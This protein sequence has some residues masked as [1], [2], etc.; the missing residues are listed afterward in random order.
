[1]AIYALDFDGNDKL[2]VPDDSSLR[3]T[4]DEATIECW[5]KWNANPTSLG[6][7]ITKEEGNAEGLVMNVSSS[8]KLEAACRC[9]SG[10]PVLDGGTTMTA[11][12]NW[13]HLA[14]VK[15]ATQLRVFLDGVEDATPI[16]ANGNIVW[17]SNAG[18][19]IGYRNLYND[20]FINAKIDEIRISKVARYTANFTP[21]T[22]YFSSDSDTILLLHLDDGS[23][24]TAVDSGPNSQDA[25]LGSSPNDPSWV[26]GYVKGKIYHTIEQSCQQALREILGYTDISLSVQQMLNKKAGVSSPLTKYSAVEAYNIIQGWDPGAY[27]DLQKA[28]AARAGISPATKYSVQQMLMMYRNGDIDLGL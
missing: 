18:W 25:T 24:S 5:I 23:G 2:W 16:A 26:A 27:K 17:S 13:H 1:M 21:Q 6:A 22:T 7:I 20:R 4:T 12:G 8:G 14:V 19:G 3:P 15:T 11:D 9:S 28:M 10:L